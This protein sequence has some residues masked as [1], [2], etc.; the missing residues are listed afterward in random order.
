[1]CCFSFQLDAGVA[2]AVTPKA[3][4]NFVTHCFF[5][6]HRCLMLGKS[7]KSLS[8]SPVNEMILLVI[9]AGMTQDTNK[10]LKISKTANL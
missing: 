8:Y 5:L 6:T 2:C 1:M 3:P 7:D 10:F 4:F 9:C